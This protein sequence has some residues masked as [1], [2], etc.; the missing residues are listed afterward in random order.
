MLARANPLGI[1]NPSIKFLIGVELKLSLTPSTH[2]ARA[3][4]LNLLIG[5]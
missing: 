4:S 2:V 5:S 3:F 1:I